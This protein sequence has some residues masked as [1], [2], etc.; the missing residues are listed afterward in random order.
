MIDVT[1]T[2][3]AIILSP[4]ISP[5]N[6]PLYGQ[7]LLDK[8][9][10]MPRD[11]SKRELAVAAG[12]TTDRNGTQVVM[13][14]GFYQALLAAQGVHFGRD[15]KCR[16]KPLNKALSGRGQVHRNGSVLIGA[17]YVDQIAG[18]RPG[19]HY[20]VSVGDGRITVIFSGASPTEMNSAEKTL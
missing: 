2:V 13:M 20:N 5:M 18:V 10:S 12:Y 7:E 6:T 14:T 15:P 1:N 3:N 16:P 9:R 11:S 19:D 17:G 8:I 4:Y